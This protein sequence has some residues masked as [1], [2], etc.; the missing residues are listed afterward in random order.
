MFYPASAA[1]YRETDVALFAQPRDCDVEGCAHTSVT[2]WVRYGAIRCDTHPPIT[3][4]RHQGVA[5]VRPA[6]STTEESS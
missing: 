6:Q 4:G 2:V 3:V 5:P 1:Y